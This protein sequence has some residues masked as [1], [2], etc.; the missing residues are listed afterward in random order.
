MTLLQLSNPEMLPPR[1]TAPI[2]AVFLMTIKYMRKFRTI[3][4][5]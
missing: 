2:R 4:Y 1:K 5:I 3:T